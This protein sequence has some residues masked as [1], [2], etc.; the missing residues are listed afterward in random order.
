MSR[1]LLELADIVRSAGQAFVDHSRRW[2]NWQHQKVLLAA[3]AECGIG[4]TMPN[5]GLC[6]M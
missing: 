4:D 5:S 6:R 2:I 3:Y 1:S